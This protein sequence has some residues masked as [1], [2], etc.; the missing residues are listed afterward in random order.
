M[1]FDSKDTE[2]EEEEV[3]V[4]D[5]EIWKQ[6]LFLNFFFFFFFFFFFKGV[7]NLIFTHMKDE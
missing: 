7:S 1:R 2:E 5:E 4:C 3:E 6:F